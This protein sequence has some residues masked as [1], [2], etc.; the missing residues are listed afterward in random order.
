MN[1]IEKNKIPLL[2]LD[3]DGV[4]NIKSI[5]K[6][7]MDIICPPPWLDVQLTFAS[8]TYF[9]DLQ[10]T[11]I[12]YSPTVI[13]QLNEWHTKKLVEIR[14]LTNWNDD[15]RYRL[16]PKLK[17]NDFINS[18]ENIEDEKYEVAYSQIKDKNERPLIWIDDELSS[19]IKLDQINGNRWLTRKKSLFIQPNPN[20]GITEDIIM[21]I[22]E[23]LLN[24]Q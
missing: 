8:H 17:L 16:A 5:N 18:R 24:L 2:L 14:W 23:F 1:E 12:C 19:L 20:L 9:G 15:A 13:Q 22:N 3:V 7:T 11:V 10:Q 21:E 4:I 6:Q